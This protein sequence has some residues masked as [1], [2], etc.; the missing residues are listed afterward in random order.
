MNKAIKTTAVTLLIISILF[1]FAACGT[2]EEPT[3][4][5]TTNITTTKQEK[6]TEEQTTEGAKT[7]TVTC[8]ST[9]SEGK[10]LTK[11]AATYA[12]GQNLVPEITWD[13]VPNAK[14]YAVYM[15]DESAKNWL[16]MMAVTTSTTIKEGEAIQGQYIGPYPPSGNHS[17]VIYVLALETAPASLPGNFNATNPGIATLSQSLGTILA[18]ASTTVTY[19][20]G[21]NN[22]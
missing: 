22:V 3:E 16:H 14:A 7:M 9:T 11:C 18:Q 21:D 19:A 5:K 10:L 17:Y 15:L 2:K 8:K 1:T 6:T 13:E 4:Q 20:N 12:N